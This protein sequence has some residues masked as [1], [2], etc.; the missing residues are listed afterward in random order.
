MNDDLSELSML[1]LF[2][3]DA[4]G[5]TQALTASLLALEHDALAADQLES[6]MRAAHS[7]KGAARIVG[8]DV[9]VG[10][11]HAMEDCFVAAQLGTLV[12]GRAQIDVLLRG[13]DLLHRIAN[14]PEAEIDQWAGAKQ[15]EVSTFIEALAAVLKGPPES[16][17][18]PAGA[19]PGETSAMPLPAHFIERRSTAAA[20]VRENA[21]R[22]LHVTPENLNRLLGL[23]G[24]SLVESRW[25]N[26]FAGSLLAL[27]RLN[28]SAGKA[29]DR[30]CES[31]PA[32]A[33]DAQGEIALAQA[34]DNLRECREVLLQR[35]VEMEMFDGRSTNL[36]H[37]LYEAVLACRMRP[38]GDGVRAFPRMVRDLSRTLGKEARLHV[39]GEATQVDRDILEKLDAPLGHLLRNALDHGIESSEERRAAG[40]SAE[41]VV[42][43]EA[44]HSAGILQIIAT[45]DGRGIDLAELRSAIVARNL[46]NE[47]TAGKL[48]EAELLEFLFLPGFSMKGS[49]TE[50]SGRGVGLDVVRDMIRQVR[51]TIHVSSRPGQGTRFELQLPLTLSVVRAL[52]VA[53]GGESY[54]FPLANIV[55]TLKLARTGI[56]LLEGRQHFDFEGRSVGLVGADRILGGAAVL[57]AG[58]ELAVIVVGDAGNAYGLVVDCFLGERELV[59][60][61]L[62][63]R[64]GKIKDIAAGALQEDGSPVLIVDVEDMVHSLDKLASAGDLGEVGSTAG[65]AGAKARKRVLVAD[66]S[67]TVRE[68]EKKLLEHAG[69]EVEVAVDGM[70]GWNAVRTGH[71]SLVITDVD[72]P[73]MDGIELVARIKKEPNLRSL[74]VMIVSYKDREHDRGRGLEA[75]ADYYLA[76]SSF[77]DETL[78][79]AVRDLIGEAQV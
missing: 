8:L 33:L 54:A 16:A 51:G 42:S 7:L 39:V 24:E 78:L 9:G 2:R 38:F 50:I 28:D 30:V 60:H 43:L 75:G 57:T 27:R 48:T 3:L 5:Q 12:L 15:A 13:V 10:V 72:M 1:E 69:Y 31:L 52:L 17:A 6:C 40:K 56:S 63:A 4:E 67:L 20:A 36:A 47:E 79:Q 49:V 18:E 44:R 59:V 37:R 71:F 32:R 61:P 41:G 53:V 21:E 55:R 64:L 58:D 65:G 68:L 29:L 66:D 11:A 26:S 34:R 76:K 46:T 74:P 77:H 35:F 22:V 25:L 45:D 62:D 70:D 19:A 14:T 73:R 23:A